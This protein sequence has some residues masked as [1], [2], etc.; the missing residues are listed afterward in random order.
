MP[1]LGGKSKSKGRE[2]RQ[3]PSRN[4][5]PS[6]TVSVPVSVVASTNA[7]FLDMPLATLV[8]TE[9]NYDDILERH[10]GGGGTPDPKH[11]ET[12]TN[13]LDLLMEI[14][15]SRSMTCD[16]ATRESLR[17]RKDEVEKERERQQASREAEEKEN[18]KRAAEDEDDVRGRKGAKLKKRKERSNVREERPLT[19]GAHGLARQDGLDLPMKGTL[20]HDPFST[21]LY[22][23]DNFSRLVLE[24]L[25]L[26]GF[27]TVFSGSC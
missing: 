16:N 25:L 26:F 24:T 27:C 13:D 7:T 14:A 5:T 8:A 18:L 17:K 4:T 2:S 23:N 19:H 9:I 10:G 1:P 11:L 20:G 15:E 21:A 3:S 6:S 12:M 22:Y